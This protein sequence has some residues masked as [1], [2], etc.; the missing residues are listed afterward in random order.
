MFLLNRFK[1]LGHQF[2]DAGTAF[3]VNSLIS[4]YS[5][6]VAVSTTDPIK[7]NHF[8]NYTVETYITEAYHIHFLGNFIILTV[9]LWLEKTRL[10]LPSIRGMVVYPKAFNFIFLAGIL[11]L[12]IMYNGLPGF[13]G[14]IRQFFIQLLLAAILVLAWGSIRYRSW[15]IDIQLFTLFSLA[16]IYNF[17]FSYLR[18]NMIL[19]ALALVL[20]LYW[21]YGTVKKLLTSIRVFPIYIF[22]ALFISFFSYF[23]LNRSSIGAGSERLIAISQEVESI[24]A[25]TSG[26][27][28]LTRFST[29]NQLTNVVNLTETKGFYNGQTLNY[30]G[31]AFIPRFLWPEKPVIAQGVWFAFEIGQALKT[32]TW[33]NNSINMTIPGEFY[34]N[35]G[36]AG[37]V[38]GCFL[39]GGF[40]AL[41]WRST[42]FWE[43]PR[44]F[45]GK[46]WGFYLLFLGFFG[47]GADLQILVTL[48]A[49]YL[50]FL[51]ISKFIWGLLFART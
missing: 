46:I 25:T 43:R 33:Y 26:S 10:K 28:F 18:V 37:V 41:L 40:W 31:F 14:T 1:Q 27:E 30:L 20:G 8:F 7:L 36:W 3:A 51:F 49:M 42:G 12:G 9:F 16:T 21:G 24:D 50:L 23:G 29:I 19:P 48:I 44:D 32:E 5:N 38:V 17:L 47:L 35:F 11:S 13:L 15:R 45:L 39:F 22:V 4:S 6:F 2:V 34:L